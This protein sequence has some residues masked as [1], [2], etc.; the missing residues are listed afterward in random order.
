MIVEDRR[1]AGER[2][3][4]HLDHHRDGWPAVLL[5]PLGRMW[6]LGDRLRR[7]LRP[8]LPLPDD[9]PSLGVGNLRVG[10]TGKT[11]VVEDLGRRLVD[12]G[13]RVAVLTRGYRAEGGGDEPG[14]LAAAG[15]GVVADPDRRRGFERARLEGADR[16]LLDDAL[17]T[18]HRARSLVALVLDRDL[19]APPRPLPAGPARG[20]AEGLE[21][22]DALLVRR[23]SPAEV[24]LPGH[25]LGFRLAPAG[26]LDATGGPADPP[27]GPVA[28]LSGLAR[29]ESFERD[30]T[31]LGLEVLA[32]RRES[33]HWSPAADAGPALTDW[34][35]QR[36]AG[37]ILV[38]EKNL[39]RVAAL[40]PGVP[41]FAL[42]SRI[43]WD[44]SSDPLA[45]LR[46]G[47][48]AI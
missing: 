36:G 45:W 14:W 1:S 13:H 46:A 35:R 22:A 15:L 41:V 16:I 39:A 32:S 30:A 34:A 17:Q 7:S 4:A 29:P 20:G 19:D 28:L 8:D 38:P 27:P 43:V 21:R 11:P 37:W 9:V 26:F 40:E 47:G 6:V 23:E 5:A 25:A 10:G 44:G 2:L 18:R 33:D 3:L 48:L 24:E 31:G 12:E 42:R